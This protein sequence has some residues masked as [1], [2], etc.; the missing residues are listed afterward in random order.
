MDKIDEQRLGSVPDFCIDA[1]SFGNVA[2]F[3]NHSCDPNLFIQCVLSEHHD[4]K[5][6]RLILF[7]ADN[8]PPLQVSFPALIIVYIVSVYPL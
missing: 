4:I 6:A 8:I 7:A 3:F 5:L 1:G 2:R